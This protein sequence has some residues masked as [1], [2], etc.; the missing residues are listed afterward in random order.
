MPCWCQT[1]EENHQ[2][3]SIWLE[4]KSNSNNQSLQPWCVWISVS[5]QYF[6]S[7]KQK[8]TTSSTPVNRK[9]ETEA[10][11]G[12]T[13]V[14]KRLPGLLISAVTIK[15]NIKAWI[16]PASYHQPLC[17]FQQYN[18]LR[19]SQTGFLKWN[20]YI[21]G[22]RIPQAYARNRDLFNECAAD[23]SAAPVWC[24]RVNMDQNLWR[25]FPA[26][27]LNLFPKDLTE[28]WKQRG[29]RLETSKV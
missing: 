19:S 5:V 27:C 6:K 17:C 7:L 23:K 4:G 9:Q 11:T 16:H 8:A 13:E 22:L 29:F 2:S 15:W 10:I 20:Q 28:L 3:A 26:P 12:S 1:S 24:C 14:N 21:N 18:M 25:I